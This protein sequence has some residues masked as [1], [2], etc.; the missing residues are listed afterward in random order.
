MKNKIN[1]VIASWS[2]RR[3]SA[4]HH[5]FLKWHLD[6]LCKYKHNLDQIT[7]LVP[8]NPNMGLLYKL[9]IEKL[10]IS[11]P[12]LPLVRLHRKNIGLSY[13]GYNDAFKQFPDFDY[14]IFME[15]DYCYVKDNFDEILI[16][17]FNQKP[18]CG[19]LCGYVRNPNIH[20][21]DAQYGPMHAGN[22]N[23]ITKREVIEKI[24]K[25]Y[26]EMPHNKGVQYEEQGGQIQW[27]RA[28][29]DVGMNLYDITPHYKS[30]FAWGDG[31]ITEYAPQNK[32][33]LFIPYQSKH[34]FPL[35]ANK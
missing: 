3:R 28:F 35:E 8:E 9:F 25:K 32:E 34:L 5:N 27:S 10:I 18:N 29:L 20:R 23:G 2:G 17:L 11:Y 31:N 6:N 33:Y 24:I 12:Q 19:Y 21:Y 7:V 14:Y 13:G 15:D 1:Y 26:G 16:D 4:A 22:S 30:T